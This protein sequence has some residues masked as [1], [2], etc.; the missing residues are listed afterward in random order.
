MS[1]SSPGLAPTCI[2]SLKPGCCHSPPHALVRSVSATSRSAFLHSA[3][4][5]EDAGPS[6][7]TAV[8]PHAYIPGY[9]LLSSPCS[10]VHEYGFSKTFC[11]FFIRNKQRSPEST[12]PPPGQ[13]KRNGATQQIHEHCPVFHEDTVFLSSEHIPGHSIYPV[14]LPCNVSAPSFSS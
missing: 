5:D 12:S 4:L 13:Q 8:C 7:T 11:F 14:T 6:W 2:S 10:P 1:V 9:E 3:T